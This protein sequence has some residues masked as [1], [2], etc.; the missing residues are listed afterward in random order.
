MIYMWAAGN[1]HDKGDRSTYDGWNNSPYTVSIGAVDDRGLMTWYSEHGP[2]LI[3]SAS[4]NGANRQAITTTSNAGY[5]DN[6][7]GTSSATPLASGAV[8]LMLQ[9][10]PN[11]GWRDVQEILI[12][13]ARKNAP[14]DRE[15]LVNGAGFNFNH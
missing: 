5:T 9:A 15:W 14:T 1:G 11:L 4:S 10:N 12:R 2:N 6:F 8:A 13:T 3:V 7:G